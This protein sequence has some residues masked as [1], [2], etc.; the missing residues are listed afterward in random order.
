MA[1]ARG[2]LLDPGGQTE[3]TFAWGLGHKTNNE[4][5]WMAL[6]QGLEF[7]DSIAISRLLVFGDSRH[8]IH[9]MI[10][11][12]S[13]CSINCKRLYDRITPLLTSRIEFF[14]I[15]R[16]NNALM[17]ALANQGASLPQEH[18]R[19]NNIDTGTKPIP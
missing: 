3:K 19:I 4:V 2:V 8:V 18:I 6:M 17:N 7:L 5:E 14:H 11:S 16:A 1:G 13:T 15:L 9:K 10:T 12:Y